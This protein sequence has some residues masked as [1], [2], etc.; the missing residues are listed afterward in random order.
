MMNLVSDTPAPDDLAHV[1]FDNVTVTVPGKALRPVPAVGT[2]LPDVSTDLTWDDAAGASTVAAYLLESDVLLDNEP[3]MGQF[4]PGVFEPGTQTL[5][6]D[7]SKESADVTGLLTAGKYY[8]WNVHVDGT[9]GYTW[10]FEASDDAIPT[11]DAGA[12]QYL[13]TT[14]SPMV[15]NLSALVTDDGT[16]TITWADSSNAGDRD[17]DTAI[18]INSAST[19]ATTVTLTNGVSGVVN[20]W[21]QFEI[22]VNDGVN[23][24]VTDQVAVGVYGTC[25]EAAAADPADGWVSVGDLDGSCKTDL[26]DFALFAGSWLD[27]NALRI[28]CP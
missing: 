18:V 13:E 12:D 24:A 6:V 4:T 1:G 14:G 19:A 2:L 22:T 21:Y 17:P 28:S 10:N 3:N 26:V 23:P 15:L 11:V 16:P 7:G 20:G 9:A 25:K 8:Y 27:C 5:T